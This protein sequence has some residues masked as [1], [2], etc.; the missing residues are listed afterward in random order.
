[1]IRPA[2]SFIFTSDSKESYKAVLERLP[3][4]L[5]HLISEDSDSTEDLKFKELM[6]KQMKKWWE[7]ED[8]WRDLSLLI[9]VV[10]RTQ[11]HFPLISYNNYYLEEIFNQ[12]TEGNYEIQKVSAKAICKLLVGNNIQLKRDEAFKKIN[13]LSTGSYYDKRRYLLFCSYAVESFAHSVLKAINVFKHFIKLSEDKISNIRLGYLKI[14]TKMWVNAC[15]KEIREEIMNSI[16]KLHE[17]TN[18]EVRNYSVKVHENLA[19]HL[20]EILKTDEQRKK[21][22]EERELKE[23]QAKGKNEQEEKKRDKGQSYKDFLKD[24]IGGHNKYKTP[25]MKN[26]GKKSVVTGRQTNI[27]VDKKSGSLLLGYQGKAQKATFG[28]VDNGK[29][30]KSGNNTKGSRSKS[31]NLTTSKKK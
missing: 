28:Q 16:K 19:N 27:S 10:A 3:E 18:T 26:V 29:G 24:T 11:Q 21:K 30:L 22:N 2:F 6:I 8:N 14:A 13:K 7:E 25:H 4:I 23:L 31:G 15:D 20:S 1:L 9:D 5:P 17:D 12:L